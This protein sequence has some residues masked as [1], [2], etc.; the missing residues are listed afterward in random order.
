M[1]IPSAVR[2]EQLVDATIEIMRENGVQSVTV[3]DVAARAKAPLAIL[4]YCFKDKDDLIHAAV[5]RWLREMI[6]DSMKFS[7]SGGVRKAVRYM[8]DSWWEGIE[9]LPQNA[10]AQFELFL[11]ALRNNEQIRLTMYPMYL[12]E[13][14]S[15]LKEALEISGE[16]CEWDVMVL[17]RSLLVIVDGCSFQ[18]LSDPEK[19][20][21]KALSYE[22]AEALFDRAK[23]LPHKQPI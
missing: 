2:R 21:A 23:I 4:H 3:R 20:G 1:R 5:E 10:Q 11:W 17:A 6:S 14:T 12:D 9:R 13:L 16:T 18:Y 7:T 19:S 8:L 15:V 22:M